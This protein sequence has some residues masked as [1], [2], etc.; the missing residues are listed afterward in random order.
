MVLKPIDPKLAR[1]ALAA[2]AVGCCWRAH[3]QTAEVKA[4][5]YARVPL[6]KRIAADPDVV[7]YVAARNASGESMDEVRRRD[8]EW[9]ARQDY[10]LRK[11][12]TGSPCAARLRALIAEDSLV[13]EAILMDKNGGTVCASQETSDYWQGDEPKWQKPFAEKLDV[14]VD[15]PALDGST[16]I[17]AVQLSVPV[18][19][20]KDERAGALCLT[21]KIRRDLV[22]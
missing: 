3:A 14:F 19:G 12:L 1:A 10:P 2:V 8:R 15:N 11:T 22:K 5:G 18:M 20:H 9:T 17:Y 4:T 6:A 16:G 13:V 7:R 21:L